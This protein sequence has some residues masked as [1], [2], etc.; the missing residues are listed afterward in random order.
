MVYSWA[1]EMRFGG[2]RV[3]PSSPSSKWVFST[4]SNVKRPQKSTKVAQTRDSTTGKGVG[5][6]KPVVFYQGSCEPEGMV[7]HAEV[8]DVA[9]Q[10]QSSTD[11]LG[12][13]GIHYMK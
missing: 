8:G 13:S 6:K 2:L 11:L 1:R 5:S 4:W 10:I 7:V 9:V 3:G 12:Y